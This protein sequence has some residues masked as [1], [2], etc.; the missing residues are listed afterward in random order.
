MK[1]T[2]YGH[3]CFAIAAREAR[4]LTDP[5]DEQVPY[6]F[7]E[8]PVDIVTIS[9][10]H[11]DH[12]AVGRVR[13]DPATIEGIGDHEAHSVRFAGIPSYH[14]DRGGAERGTNTIL[15]FTLEGVTIAHLGDLGTPLDDTQRRTLAAVE[16][17]FLPVGG[18]FTIDAGQASDIVRSLPAVR[19]AIPM[20]YRTERI[21]DWPIA[22]V[23]E[24]EG[25]MDNVRHVGTSTVE[26]TRESLPELREVWILDHVDHF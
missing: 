2:W 26:L 25:L 9:H 23:E 6:A 5:F 10:G 24:F 20:H 11:F 22:T 21:A 19:V 16:V 8:S 18:H 14:D 7:P 4:L 3:A 1:I 17:L 12:N 15:V 13:G